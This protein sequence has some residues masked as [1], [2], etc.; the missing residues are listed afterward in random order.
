MKTSLIALLSVFLFAFTCTGEKKEQATEMEAD[1]NKIIEESNL[2]ADDYKGKLDELLTLEMA[3]A[4]SGYPAADAKVTPS[5]EEKANYQKMLKKEMPSIS[6]SY[7]WEKSNR[8]QSMEVM[9]RKIDAPKP[10]RVELSWVKPNTIEGFKKA[11]HNPTEQEIAAGNKA[12]DDK[13][14]E[15]SKDPKYGETANKAGKSLTNNVMKNF[16]VEEVDGV[17][18]YAVFA[19]TKFAGVP[20]RELAVYY[21]GLSFQLTVDLSDDKTVNDEK[22]IALAKRIINEKLK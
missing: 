5:A 11:F 18:E 17:G 2:V 14:N 4:T 12:I 8:T 16:S 7:T 19:N 22:A 20:M 21:K 3:S 9:G 15:M 13:L 1:L 6:I 10:D